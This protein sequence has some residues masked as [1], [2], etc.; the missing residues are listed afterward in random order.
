MKTGSALLFLGFL[1]SAGCASSDAG[2]SW[3]K[4]EVVRWYTKSSG[5]VRFMGYQ[6]SDS[7]YHHFIARVMDSWTFIQVSKEELQLPDERVFAGTSSA[8]LYYYLVDPAHGF[9]KIEPKK[10]NQS[11]EPT[12]TVRDFDKR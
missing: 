4:P 9:S 8:Q 2:R 6:G 1:F 3:T 5:S 10:A 11:L 12:A 7:T